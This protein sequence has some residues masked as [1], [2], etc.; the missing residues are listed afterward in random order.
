MD[1]SATRLDGHGLEVIRGVVLGKLSGA[2]SG[3]NGCKILCR[4][5]ALEVETELPLESAR[6]CGWENKEIFCSGDWE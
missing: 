1:S 4:G 5:K 6:F 3:E 2:S